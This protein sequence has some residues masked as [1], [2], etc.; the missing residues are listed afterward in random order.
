MA[1][2]DLSSDILPTIFG[3]NTGLTYEQLKRRQA[4]AT[5]LAA[6]KRG[7]PKNLGE[8]IA[9]LGDRLRENQLTAA[10]KAYADKRAGWTGPGGTPPVVPPVAAPVRPPAAAAP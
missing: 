4:V 7:Y 8:G 6:Q 10:E 5:A 9:G 3:G 1:L 2:D